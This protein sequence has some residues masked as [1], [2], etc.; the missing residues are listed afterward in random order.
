MPKTLSNDSSRIYQ[1][2]LA[3]LGS[4]S[5]SVFERGKSTGSGVFASLGSGLQG[6]PTTVFCKISVRRSKYRL[7]FPSIQ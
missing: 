5:N 6:H 7:E 3:T 4:L 2:Q 1:E